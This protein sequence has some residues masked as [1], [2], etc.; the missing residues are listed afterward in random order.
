MNDRT[1]SGCGWLIAFAVTLF[2]IG[3]IFVAASGDDG[4]GVEVDIDHHKPRPTLTK[5]VPKKKT[6]HKAPSFRS[7]TKR[8]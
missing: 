4:G 2:I 6:A 8:R 7:G 5:V 3:F 1:T